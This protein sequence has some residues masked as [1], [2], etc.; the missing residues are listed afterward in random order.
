MN[1]FFK[2]FMMKLGVNFKFV[3]YVFAIKSVSF[4]T[5]VA[6][7]VTVANKPASRY[8]SVKLMRRSVSVDER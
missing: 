3:S 6:L 1:I 7:Y 5:T 4:I 8:P 2:N